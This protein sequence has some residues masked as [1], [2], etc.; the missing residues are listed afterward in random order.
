MDGDSSTR[1]LARARSGD[2]SALEALF[3]R[4]VPALQ[5]W[6]SGRLP[7]WARDSRDTADLVQDAALQTLRH[8]PTFRPT[9]KGALQAYLRQAVMNLIRDDVR[10]AGRR[11]A[12]QTLRDVVS[13]DASPLDEAIDRDA[14][15]R[16]ERGLQRLRL[17][18][19]AAIV[20]R[21]E[22]GY[23]YEQLA[24]ALGKPTA[25]AARVAVIRAIAKLA[26]EMRRDG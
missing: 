5:R 15:L 8:V 25:G 1:L 19:R 12:A 3:A 14:A 6:A 17:E 11:P 21:I 2:S 24:T 13:R 22:R 4:Y 16:Y 23:D 7:R 18:E 20:Y 9:R 26:E 10:R